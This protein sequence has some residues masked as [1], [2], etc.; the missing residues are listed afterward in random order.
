MPPVPRSP[1]ATILKRPHWSADDARVVL[2]ALDDAGTTV[3]DF[4]RAHDLDPQRLYAWRRRLHRDPASDRSLR[5]VEL[6]SAAAP[7]STT[8][9]E[10]VL[11]S[12][13]RLH[14]EG[15]VVAGDVATLL[16]LLRTE[17][18]PC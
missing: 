8:R 1:L 16:T 9:Y 3:A 14:I 15:T 12:G 18:A 10:I 6:P 5:F 13:A 7:A 11:P 4:A 2:D 17:S